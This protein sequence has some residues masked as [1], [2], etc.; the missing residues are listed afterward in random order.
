MHSS[1]LPIRT[2][3]LIIVDI[4]GEFFIAPV[5]WYSRGLLNILRW[6]GRKLSDHE[7]KLGLKLWARNLFVP[8]YAQT[9]WQGRLISF[10]MRSIFLFIKTL[11]MLFWLLWYVGVIIIWLGAPILVAWQIWKQI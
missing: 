4:F 11:I 3:K 7:E 9:D 1:S 5:W 2:A 10:F 8:M 6:A